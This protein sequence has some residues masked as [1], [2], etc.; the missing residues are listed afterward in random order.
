MHGD[1]AVLLCQTPAPLTPQS[2]VS[3]F[4][5][6][7]LLHSDFSAEVQVPSSV[8][9]TVCSAPPKFRDSSQVSE[10]TLSLFVSS[11]F[12][13]SAAPTPQRA[14][15]QVQVSLQVSK[16]VLSEFI[17]SLFQHSCLLITQES[18][19]QVKF[20]A[21]DDFPSPSPK[22]LPGVPPEGVSVARDEGVGRVSVGGYASVPD[23][24][25]PTPTS[26]PH[27]LLPTS[28]SRKGVICEDVAEQRVAECCGVFLDTNLPHLSPH[29]SLPPRIFI[30]DYFDTKSALP[31]FLTLMSSPDCVSGLWSDSTHLP[32]DTT[33]FPDEDTVDVN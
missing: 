24:Y 2:A 9:G 27:P 23:C 18:T 1:S 19:N 7:V 33:V 10:D 22:F 13:N 20:S 15:E 11:L 30:C 28:C 8:C 14:I 21:A 12:E 32:P 4:T 16:D 17:S 31:F 26:V 5:E 3:C 29:L 6:Q 25:S